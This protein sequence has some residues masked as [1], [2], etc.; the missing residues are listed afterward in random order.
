MIQDYHKKIYVLKYKM[1]NILKSYRLML[2]GD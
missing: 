2:K 1:I